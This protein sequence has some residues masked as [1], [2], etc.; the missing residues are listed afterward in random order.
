VTPSYANGVA[1]S[2]HVTEIPHKIAFVRTM[3]RAGYISCA[4]YAHCAES[5]HGLTEE[6]QVMERWV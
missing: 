3:E 4:E 6:R 5:D 2:V 1:C